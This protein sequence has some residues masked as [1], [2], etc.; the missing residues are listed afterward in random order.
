MSLFLND[1]PERNLKIRILEG[2]SFLWP[3]VFNL[4]ITPK[5]MGHNIISKIANIDNSFGSKNNLFCISIDN[6]NKKII[7]SMFLIILPP[8]INKFCVHHCDLLIFD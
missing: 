7:L 8:F 6:N 3:P 5:V 2:L 4:V 1:R